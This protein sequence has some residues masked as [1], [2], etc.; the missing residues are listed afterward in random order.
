M[1]ILY[2]KVS[3]SFRTREVVLI[4]FI[5]WTKHHHLHSQS[6]YTLCSHERPCETFAMHKYNKRCWHEGAEH[7]T[8]IWVTRVFIIRL[9]N[10]AAHKTCRCWRFQLKSTWRSCNRCLCGWRCARATHVFGAFD[11]LLYMFGGCYEQ[12]KRV[13]CANVYN[14]RVKVCGSH[15]IS[16][17]PNDNVHLDVWRWNKTV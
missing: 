13:G 7:I 5:I 12:L 15:G 17:K 2:S 10:H 16:G 14:D 4:W 1:Y 9:I 11:R 3:R 8:R 6:T